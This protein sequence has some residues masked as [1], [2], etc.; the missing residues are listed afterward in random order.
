MLFY[1]P[2]GGGDMQ[3]IYKSYRCGKCKK[4]FVLLA[5]QE[6]KHRG[7]LVCPYCS[8]RNVT[9]EGEADSV[10]ECMKHDAFKREHGALRQV[11]RE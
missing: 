7:Y 9:L 10:R 1:A 3:K 5:E 6:E 8:S 4:E 11:R 2:E